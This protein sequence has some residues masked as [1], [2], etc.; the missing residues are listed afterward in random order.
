[1]HITFVTSYIYIYK[2]IYMHYFTG[3]K[4]AKLKLNN[5]DN[6]H[7]KDEILLYM[8]GR[9]ISSMSAMWK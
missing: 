6:I 1:M 7:D 5:A 8:R 4:K 2:C 9:K 3:A